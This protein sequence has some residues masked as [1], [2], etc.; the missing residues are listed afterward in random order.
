MEVRCRVVVGIRSGDGGGGDV[1]SAGLEM[2]D[3]G[4]TAKMLGKK[5]NVTMSSTQ[6]GRSAAQCSA[7]REAV[8]F[9]FF[10]TLAGSCTLGFPNERRHPWL[11]ASGGG[12]GWGRGL[13]LRKLSRCLGRAGGTLLYPG[14]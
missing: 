8:F 14:G 4:K 13:P 5:K 7:A 1:K 10:W 6:V 12:G 2:D 9:C 3:F 11:W